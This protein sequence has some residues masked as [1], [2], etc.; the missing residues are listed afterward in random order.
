MAVTLTE[1][2]DALATRLATVTG[3]RQ[4]ADVPDNPNPPIAVIAPNTVSYDTAFQGGLTT[5]TFVI[6]VIVRQ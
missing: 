4:S 2:R 3:L 6:T 5:Y 1:I